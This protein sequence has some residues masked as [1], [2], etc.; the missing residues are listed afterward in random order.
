[1]TAPIP[2]PTDFRPGEPA[3]WAALDA[4]DRVVDLAKARAGLAV[5]S[6][7]PTPAEAPDDRP[8]AVLVPLFEEDGDL[9]V[10]LTLRNPNLRSHAGQVSFPGG[11]MDPGEDAIAAALREAREETALDPDCVEI[12]GE[13]DHLRTVVSNSF[14]VP[15][16]GVLPGRQMLT[17]NPAEVDRIFDVSTADLLTDGVYREERWGLGDVDRAISFFEVGGETVWGATGTMLRNFLL[18]S[19]GLA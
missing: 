11:R 6:A 7:V 5:H 10:V 1:V 17:A 18:L 12:I 15:I 4:A 9:R 3:P 14:I 16:V 19:L 2:R 8:S 13:L